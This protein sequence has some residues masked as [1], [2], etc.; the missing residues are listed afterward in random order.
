MRIDGRGESETGSTVVSWSTREEEAEKRQSKIKPPCE[1][2]QGEGLL[3]KTYWGIARPL[4][5]E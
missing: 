5:G 2:C 4:V 3:M 1:P